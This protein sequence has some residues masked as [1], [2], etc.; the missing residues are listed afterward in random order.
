MLV[1]ALIALSCSTSD[2]DSPPADPPVADDASDAH[3]PADPGPTGEVDTPSPDDG[4]PPTDD[5]PP[6]TDE[7]DADTD[8]PDA[9]TETDAGGCKPPDRTGEPSTWQV[10]DVCRTGGQLLGVWGTGPHDVWAVGAKGQVLRY[11]G[12]E[13]TAPDAGTDADLWW[14]FGFEGGPVFLSGAGGT[15]LRWTAAAGFEPLET[16]VSITLYGIWGDAPEDLWSVGFDAA[17]VEPSAV[18]RWDGKTWTKVTGLPATVGDQTHF[19][20]VWGSGPS[21]VWVVGRDDLILHWDGQQWADRASGIETDWITVTGNGP[22]DVVIVGGKSQGVIA[23]RE[24]DGWSTVGPDF[25]Q[26]LQGVCLQPDGTALA[27][28]VGATFVRRSSDGAWAEDLEAPFDLFS[29]FDPPVEGCQSP[30]PDYHACFADGA[31]GFYAVGGNFFGPLTEGALLHYGPPASS[32]G[33]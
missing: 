3:T 14:V 18:M 8:P 6:P 16:G 29:P 2:G 17:G 25:V 20:K 7:G 4:P 33:L 5:G 27:T 28:G 23:K 26:T 24:G 30:T 21:D 1:L 32:D 11:D 10:L 9:D 22:G 15:M 13:W 19:F 12:C 31:G